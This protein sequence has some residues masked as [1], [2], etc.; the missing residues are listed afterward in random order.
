MSVLNTVGG[1]AGALLAAGATL[2]M[3]VDPNRPWGVAAAGAL[4]AVAVAGGCAVALRHHS[5]LPRR[6]VQSI[7]ALLVV[8]SALTLICGAALLGFQI[9]KASGPN[10]SE[11]ESK[12]SA[13]PPGAGPGM[14]PG[15]ASTGTKPSFTPSGDPATLRLDVR[16][17]IDGA[18]VARPFDLYGTLSDPLPDGYSIWVTNRASGTDKSTW[19]DT[20]CA[21]SDVDVACSQISIGHDKADPESYVVEVLLAS[22][23]AAKALEISSEQQKS[24]PES[25]VFHE[26]RPEGTRLL[27]RLENVRLT[28][29]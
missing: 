1:I 13:S 11:S 7:V 5:T 19:H 16:I 23:D 6:K 9:T 22:A 10:T 25:P 17:K 20:P 29:E 2:L 12:Q 18:K 4:S 26:G 14:S 21:V 3:V 15:T 24:A 27:R 8:T 28:G